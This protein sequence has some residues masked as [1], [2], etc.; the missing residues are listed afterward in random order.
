MAGAPEAYSIKTPKAKSEDN[1]GDVVVQFL[2]S[3]DAF[4]SGARDQ[5]CI[6]VDCP[7]FRF[8]I[9]CG[10][11][12]LISM[13]RWGVSPSA[14]DAI[15]ITHLHGDHFGGIPFFILDAQIISRRTKPLVIA[16]PPGLERRIQS[17]MEIFFPGSSKIQQKFALQF[18]E[19]GNQISMP[20]GP[21][22]VKAFH[23]LHASGDPAL[24]IRLACC[25]KTIAYS[26]D[27]EWTDALVPAAQGADLF[28]CEAYFFDKKIK[29][30]MDYA[31]LMRHRPELG[32]RRLVVTH[33][34]EDMLARIRDL[35]AETAEDGK[36][37]VL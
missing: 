11:S 8:L 27:T 15:L 26:G 18:V 28:I 30:H 12:G 31:T 29:F 22:T 13:K 1:M 19:L 32:C 37:V 3:G 24:A 4:G 9:D 17:A 20:I 36:R 5:T 33:M 10:A 2:G 35:E 34:G 6:Y 14:V 25:G 21:L 16:G 23:V 7:D